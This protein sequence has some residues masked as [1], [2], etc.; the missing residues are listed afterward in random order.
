MERQILSYGKY[1]PEFYLSISQEVQEKIDYVF[2]LVKKID[3]VP[4]RFLKHLDGTDG[5]YEIRVEYQNNI[6]RIFCFFDKGN[7]II[8]INSFQKKAQ[9]I[10]KREIELAVKLKK[11]YFL[12]KQITEENEVRKK[13]KK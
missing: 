10:P 7:L 13:I 12:D 4:K 5:I 1:F 8:L 2:E 9:K 3:Q 11:Q 6:Y